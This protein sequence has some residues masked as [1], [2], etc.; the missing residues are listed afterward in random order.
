[1]ERPA[2]SL[3]APLMG[4]ACRARLGHAA[5]KHSKCFQ[6]SGKPNRRES[7][8][9]GFDHPVGFISSCVVHYYRL[10]ETG[11]C[12]GKSLRNGAEPDPEPRKEGADGSARSVG[13]TAVASGTVSDGSGR[14]SGPATKL[15]GRQDILLSKPGN[16]SSH[17]P[18]E[19]KEKIWRGEF[20]DIFSLIRPM[21][22][23]GE[24]REKDLKD[25]SLEEKRPKVE[26]SITNWLFEFNVFMTVM[27]EKRPQLAVSMIFLQIRLLKLTRHIAGQPG[28]TMIETLEGKVEDPEIGWGQTEVNVWLES[29]N[30]AP[31]KQLFRSQ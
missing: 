28:W 30:K 14:D 10:T 7:G 5:R 18:L 11:G 31:L 19:V 9:H 8:R 20:V 15:V 16:L 6:G 1:M 2:C 3:P 17:M 13:S 4:G 12:L 29:M 26:E 23:E 27:L 25:R 21:R 24:A 22:R